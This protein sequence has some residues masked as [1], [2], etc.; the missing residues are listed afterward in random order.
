MFLAERGFAPRGSN[1]LIVFLQ[2]D[3][4]FECLELI[5]KFDPFLAAHINNFGNVGR[6]KTFYRSSTN[7]EEVAEARGIEV[8]KKKN[9]LRG[10]ECQVLLSF[11]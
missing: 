6:G 7:V 11:G 2:N 5:A 4:F 1:N 8:R 9:H 10:C 3:N